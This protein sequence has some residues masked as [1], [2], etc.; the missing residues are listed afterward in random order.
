MVI[1]TGWLVLRFEE[2]SFWIA[3]RGKEYGPFDYQ[4][5]KDLHGIELM[6]AGDKFGEFVSADQLHA[7]LSEY[8]LPRKVSKIAAVVLGSIAYG[9]GQG[10][11]ESTR[12]QFALDNLIAFVNKSPQQ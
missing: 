5:S 12:K 6:F 9:I 2:T 4:W 11:D 8:E 7:D 10:W 1:V 3:H